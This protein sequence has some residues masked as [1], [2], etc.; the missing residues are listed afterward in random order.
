LNNSEKQ[1]QLRTA[2]EDRQKIFST[3]HFMKEICEFVDNDLQL[4]HSAKSN[5]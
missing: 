3:E 1:Q 5:N 2:L 4:S